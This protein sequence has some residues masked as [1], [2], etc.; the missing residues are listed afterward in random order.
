MHR[1]KLSLTIMLLFEN[2]EIV[3]N[4]YFNFLS[5]HWAYHNMCT[6][7]FKNNV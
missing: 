3:S 2:I 1:D 5:R 6:Y 4:V 7:N